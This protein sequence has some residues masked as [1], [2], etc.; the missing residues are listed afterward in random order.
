MTVTSKLVLRRACG[1]A[2]LTLLQAGVGLLLPLAAEAEQTET[3]AVAELPQAA[4]KKLLETVEVTAPAPAFD[5]QTAV[6]TLDQDELARPLTVQSL[7]TEAFR[8][9]GGRKVEDVQDFLPGVFSSSGDA[10][11]RLDDSLSIRGFENFYVLVN[12]VRHLRVDTGALSLGNIERIE[13]I[14]G[15]A[16]VES[17]TVEPGGALNLVTKKPQS[18]RSASVEAEVGSF[19][20]A[21]LLADATGPIGP[22]L[23]Y[24]LVAGGAR[25]GSFR[26][27]PDDELF[28]APSLSFSPFESQ[29]WLLETRASYTDSGYDTG[30][31]YLQDAGLAGNYAPRDFSYQDGESHN[32]QRELRAALYGRQ[33]LA[34]HTELRLNVSL[35]GRST[36]TSGLLAFPDTLYAGGAGSSLSYS[37]NPV[38]DRSPFER[39][40]RGQRGLSAQLL[41]KQDLLF[42]RHRHQFGLGVQTNEDRF[43]QRLRFGSR[44][45]PQNVFD[46]RQRF[47]ESD[48]PFNGGAQEEDN[49]GLQLPDL[50]IGGEEEGGDSSSGPVDSLFAARIKQRS[51]F[52]QYVG[53]ADRWHWLAGW[54]HDRTDYRV[55]FV[56]DPA[57]GP[58]V[59]R[60][61]S[62]SDSVRAGLSYRLAESW[63]L[64]GTLGSAYLPQG[65]PTRSGAALLPSRAQSGEL[66]LRQRTRDGRQF[67]I[68]LF[69]VRVDRFAQPDP[70][71]NPFGIF[72]IDT[73]VLR[74]Q[75]IEL[76]AAQELP[77]HRRVSVFG[78]YLDARIVASSQGYEGRRQPNVPYGSGG[79]RIYQGFAALGLPATGLELAALH[80]GSR[81]P[82]LFYQY[83]PRYTLPSYTR[84]DLFLEHA[85]GPATSLQ[86]RVENLLDRHYIVSAGSFPGYN[87]P[88]D[89]LAVT[90]SWRK[91]F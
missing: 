65:G 46:S 79:I 17:G 9:G 76:L 48:Q 40:N 44:F 8:D 3:L 66:G 27:L 33:R 70:V 83:E 30:L 11:F 25:G 7:D 47:P 64:Y 18:R 16:G 20:R 19:E 6:G 29:Q 35:E 84:V 69:K 88:G 90:A 56:D 45:R 75:G 21:S 34:E 36:Q 51:G 62:R 23:A 41:L 74:S 89:P 2:L 86:L 73:G 61:G 67:E 53:D 32:R 85:L 58:F 24:R 38:I 71:D 14:K 68:N 55:T 13:V 42:D 72:S 63:V 4:E 15:A 87:F 39:H 5:A 37:G 59:D 49:P 12:G 54:R 10:E 26:N 1:I 78:S 60:F 57:E 52:V 28:I 80:V 43:E 81:R 77:G 82:N 31:F 91:R 50:G 22:R